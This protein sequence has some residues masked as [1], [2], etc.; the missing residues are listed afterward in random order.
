MVRFHEQMMG[1]GTGEGIVPEEDWTDQ[2]Y[3][4]FRGCLNN[5]EIVLSNTEENCDVFLKTKEVESKKIIKLLYFESDICPNLS[6]GWT[7]I[8]KC[9]EINK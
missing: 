1:N 2:D 3:N 4:D 6:M 7:K 5:G 8:D 9:N